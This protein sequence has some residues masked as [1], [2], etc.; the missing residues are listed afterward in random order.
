[1]VPHGCVL[2]V[3]ST[4]FSNIGPNRGNTMNQNITIK[5]SNW[6]IT[7]SEKLN[8]TLHNIKKQTNEQNKLIE[9]EK[10][11]KH[12]K[13]TPVV[14]TVSYI[15]SGISILVLI[16]IIILAIKLCGFN[17]LSCLCKHRVTKRVRRSSI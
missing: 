17:T 3:G 6:R 14:L 13:N 15:S 2:Y 11:L 9:T 5:L 4:R 10:L 8:L 16:A 7:E 1:M 12:I